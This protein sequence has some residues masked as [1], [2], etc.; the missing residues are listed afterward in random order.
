[1]K[2]IIKKKLIGLFLILLLLLPSLGF[3]FSYAQDDLTQETTPLLTVDN[4][5]VSAKSSFNLKVNLD[6]I[7][8]QNF[9]I[10]ITPNITLENVSVQ[11]QNLNISTLNDVLTISGDI[12]NLSSNE[13][14]ISYTIPENTTIDS[15]IELNAHVYS[16]NDTETLLLEDTASIKVI[17][18]SSDSTSNTNQDKNQSTENSKENN[19]VIPS[20]TENFE[21]TAAKQMTSSNQETSQTSMSGI[22]TTTMS[23]SKTSGETVTYNGS[24]N[25]YLSNLLI[26]S[27]DLT[28]T[29]TKTNTSYFVSLPSDTTSININAVAEDSS[30]TICV[31]GNTNL[32]SGTNKI[33]ISVTSESGSV[34][35]YRIYATIK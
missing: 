4:T 13:L 2:K 6:L 18:T 9:I 26:E 8:I 16:I 22:S 20:N 35:T 11:A 3:Y 27:Y 12:E 21:S 29:F 10:T 15:I 14:L 31:Y 5:E 1:M 28:T 17:A 7:E 30:A 24:D 23:S 19:G 25:N 32:T 33:L 34:R